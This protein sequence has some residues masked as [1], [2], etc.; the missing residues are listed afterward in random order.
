MM[1]GA[2]V[3]E[4]EEEMMMI[5]STLTPLPTGGG[6]S[7]AAAEAAARPPLRQ[8]LDNIALKVSSVEEVSP[9][10]SSSYLSTYQPT[11]LHMVPH[12]T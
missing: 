7:S 12:I 8:G 6:G 5:D 11:N 2:A 1:P 9:K 3:D 4:V 10:A